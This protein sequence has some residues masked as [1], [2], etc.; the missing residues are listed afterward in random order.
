MGGRFDSSRLLESSVCLNNDPE[1]RISALLREA[2]I[3]V[4]EP[5]TPLC[6]LFPISFSTSLIRLSS[7]KTKAL[8]S[9]LLLFSAAPLFAEEGQ[10][11]DLNQGQKLYEEN[12]VSCHQ[13]EVYTRAD[14]KVTTLK[15]LTSQVRRCE[16]MLGLKWF[17]EDVDNTAAWLNKHYYKFPVE[18]P[19]P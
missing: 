17:D 1:D 7:M 10:S 9:T 18:E 12:C 13:S 6:D 5:H 19:K 8:F 3:K 15:G 4:L 14:R 2:R 16:L 11:P